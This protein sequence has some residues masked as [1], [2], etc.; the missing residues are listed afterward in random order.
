MRKKKLGEGGLKNGSQILRTSGQTLI[1]AG[2]KQVAAF[3]KITNKSQWR[4]INTIPLK[5]NVYHPQGMV[6]IGDYFYLSTVEILK[7]PKV[8]ETVS[9]GFDRSS[10]KGQALLYQIDA[11]GKLI[12]KLSLRDDSHYHPGGIDYDGK[13][14]W[15]PVSEYRPNSSAMIYCVDPKTMKAEFI[16]KFTDHIGAVI[17]DT[18]KKRLYGMNWGSQNAYRWTNFMS[19]GKNNSNADKKLSVENNDIEY[20]DG[21]FLNDNMAL[22]SGMKGGG[23]IEIGGI[24]LVNLK[25]MRMIHSISVKQQTKSKH[26]MTRNPFFF[27]LRNKQSLFYFLPEDNKNGKIYVYEVSQ[28]AASVEESPKTGISL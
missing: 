17:F 13:Y 14:I 16:F 27:D 24:D 15:V 1:G 8:Y 26:V 28:P 23:P 2:A 22:C 7:R 18:D 10:G 20:Q 25:D 6:K 4:L 9:N 12:K 5:F 21:Q 19:N 3:K 11:K